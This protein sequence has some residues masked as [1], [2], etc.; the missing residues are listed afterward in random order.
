M[1]EPSSPVDCNRRQ[2]LA[3]TG[4]A[5]MSPW[6]SSH[7]LAHP[8]AS[9]SQP[10]A[11]AAEPE[12]ID[13][14]VHVW[15][16]YGRGYPLAEGFAESDVKPLSFTPIELFAH[17][18]PA[19]VTRVVLI[20]MNFFGFDNRYMLDCI[21]AHP[22][23]FSGVAVID[24]ERADLAAEM[25]RL[26]SL[27]VRGYRLYASAQNV[28]E[29]ERSDGMRRL[30]EAGAKHG[31]AMC[32]LSDP[33]ALPTIDAWAEKYP[34]TTVVIDHFSRIS[35]RGNADTAAL[36]RLCEMARRKNLF[37]KTSAF[38]ALGAKQPPYDDLIPMIRRLRDAYGADRLMWAS[39]CPYQVQ[40]PHHYA[41]SIALI[42]DRI[43]FLSEAE[44]IAMLRG[45][46]QRVFF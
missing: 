40:A 19:N 39:D 31:Q 36:D 28:A 29:W 26:R 18:R 13:A 6:L 45:T 22:G 25:K 11:V 46:A 41:V 5:A 3:L 27:G 23:V 33:E 42:R 12:W 37:I 43:D 8:V 14:H 1:S 10:S 38:Y 9:G 17:C 24:H 20:Q 4:A 2:W 34:E 7:A 30:F 35:M 32:M 44:R 15:P 21:A 16:S